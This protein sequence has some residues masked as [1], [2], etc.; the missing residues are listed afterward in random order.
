[1]TADE[2]KALIRALIVGLPFVRFPTESIE[3]YERAI[4]DLDVALA[5]K[6]VEDII[7]TWTLARVPPVGEIRAGVSRLSAQAIGVPRIQDVPRHPSMPSADDWRRVLPEMLEREK[8]HRNIVNVERRRR[9]LAPLTA[10]QFD[11]CPFLE[12]AGRGA[13]GKVVNAEAMSRLLGIGPQSAGERHASTGVPTE[14][15]A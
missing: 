13:D 1:L 14:E 8:R 7:Q 11:P 4:A 15:Q 2:A 10:K 3:Y 9:R 5:Q 12:L 6:S